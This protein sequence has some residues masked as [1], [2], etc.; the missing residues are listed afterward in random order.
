M[1]FLA[2]RD[3]EAGNRESWSIEIATLFRILREQFS[4]QVENYRI[5][6]SAFYNAKVY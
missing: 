6:I 3:M 1:E 4:C 2:V 5:E